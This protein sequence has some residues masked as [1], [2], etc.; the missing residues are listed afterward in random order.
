MSTDYTHATSHLFGIIVKSCNY[1]EIGF[2]VPR[3]QI[4]NGIPILCRLLDYKLVDYEYMC[5]W[6]WKAV[7]LNRFLNVFLCGQGNLEMIHFNNQNL[8][9]GT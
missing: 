7:D 1:Y 6:H 3:T 2:H 9:E 4:V 8:N 5:A